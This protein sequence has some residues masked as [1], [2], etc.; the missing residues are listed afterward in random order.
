MARG[1]RERVV[2]KIRPGHED[3]DGARASAYFSS[4]KVG[5]G[6]VVYV[7][8]VKGGREAMIVKTVGENAE[9]EFRRYKQHAHG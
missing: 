6:E 5:K 4:L 2:Y 7:K 3:L 1:V 9:A 8:D